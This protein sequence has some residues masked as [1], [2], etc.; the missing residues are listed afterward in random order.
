MAGAAAAAAAALLLPLLAAARGVTLVLVLIGLSHWRASGQRGP[1]RRGRPL[2]TAGAGAGAARTLQADAIDVVNTTNG[3]EPERRQRVDA[4][5]GAG[6]SR[7]QKELPVLRNSLKLSLV[8]AG[9]EQ[10]ASGQA[11]VACQ[12]QRHLPAAKVTIGR[13]TAAAHAAAVARV[14]LVV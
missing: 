14:I 6:H 4:A 8:I 2:C 3:Q 11:C 5:E 9:S 13:P 10:E 1:C 12:A 7:P